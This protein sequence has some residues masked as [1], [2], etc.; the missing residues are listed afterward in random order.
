MIIRDE[1]GFIGINPGNKN[2]QNNDNMKKYLSL[3]LTALLII[4]AGC[5]KSDNSQVEGLLQTVPADANGVAVINIERLADAIGCKCDGKKIELTSEVKL[6]LEKSAAGENARKALTAICDGESGI[7]LSSLV[8]FSASRDYVTGLLDDPEKFIAFVQK[9]QA[10]DSTTV[11]VRKAGDVRLVGHAA[12]IGNQFWVSYPGMPDEEQLQHYLTLKGPQS[13]ADNDAASRLVSDEDVVTFVADISR[14]ISDLPDKNQ[15]RMGMSVIFEDPAYLAGGVTVKKKDVSLSANILN[16]DLK[17]SKLLIPVDKI[18]T[19]MVKD[20]DGTAEAFMALAL[21][22]ELMKKIGD[23]ASM[24]GGQ[25]AMVTALSQ[26]EGTVAV[27]ADE[28]Y[29]NVEARVHSSGKDFIQ[30][31]QL[32]QMFGAQVTRDG[33]ILTISTG[34][35]S[36]QGALTS[37]DA[38]SQFKG[39]WLGMMVA[40]YPG[41]DS[42]T[43]ATLKEDNKSLRLDVT[44]DGG[45]DDLLTI[46]FK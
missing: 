14:A 9:Q 38:A 36:F 40:H 35:R 5:S 41:R 10:T 20:F 8:Y 37:V 24:A 44:V 19:S 16:S 27:R 13:F 26:I 4:A 28:N 29:Q 21:P 22:K 42:S 30:L 3:I 25:S 46:L 33:D 23:M 32:L 31:T 39:A 11:E 34:Q 12:V 2:D 17:P 7:S 1:S 15:I 18:D 43:V 6:A 45:V